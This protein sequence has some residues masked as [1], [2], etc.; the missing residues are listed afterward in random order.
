M[1]IAGGHHEVYTRTRHRIWIRGPCC[2]VGIQICPN[3]DRGRPG[4]SE[5]HP[6]G[7]AASSAVPDLELLVD[8]VAA[9]PDSGAGALG[10]VYGRQA[11]G[12]SLTLPLI[13]TPTPN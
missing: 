13:P 3:L 4:A 5:Q 11:H 1:F 12:L 8:P 10:C 2:R 7:R 6:D 9:V